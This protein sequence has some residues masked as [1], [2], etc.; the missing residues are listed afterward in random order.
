MR[1]VVPISCLLFAWLCANGALW[2]AVQ[3]VAW[4]KMFHDYSAVMPVADA[5][6]LTFDGSKPCKLCC[7]AKAAEDTARKQ[8]PRD[9]ALGGGTEK[10][11]FIAEHAPVVVLP[12]PRF[13]WPD[14]DHDIGWARKEA[15]PVPPPRA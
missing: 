4:V 1:R 2:N 8:M 3:V 5:L 13:T 9:S 14:L 10:L 6:Q 12:A 11:L 15:V 7:M